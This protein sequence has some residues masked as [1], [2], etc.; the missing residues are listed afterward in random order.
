MFILGYAVAIES[1]AA[2]IGGPAETFV[3]EIS[4]L[5]FTSIMLFAGFA[6]FA[7]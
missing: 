5:S 7:I 4:V 3:R 1:P 2:G 6:A